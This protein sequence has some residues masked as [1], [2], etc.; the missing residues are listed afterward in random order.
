MMR[1][2]WLVQARDM[3]VA[4]IRYRCFHPAVALIGRGVKSAVFDSPI[5]LVKEIYKFDAVVIVKRLD[6]GAI[7]VAVAAREGGKAVLFDFCDDILSEAYRASMRE[8]NRAVFRAIAPLLDAVVTTGPAMTHRLRQYGY[9]LPRVFEIPDIAETQVELEAVAAFL[10]RTTTPEPAPKSEGAAEERGVVSTAEPMGPTMSKRAAALLD[11]PDALLRR[12]AQSIARSARRIALRGVSLVRHGPNWMGERATMVVRNPRWSVLRMAHRVGLPVSAGPPPVTSWVDG[13]GR[14]LVQYPLWSAMRAA[15]RLGLPVRPGPLPSN[16]IHADVTTDLA[17]RPVSTRLRLAIQNPGWTARRV[18]QRAG[19]PLEA[20]QLPQA[21]PSVPVVIAP[22]PRPPFHPTAPQAPPKRVVW[23]GNHGAPHSNFGVLSLIPAAPALRAVH[24]KTPI[25]LIVISNDRAK[26]EAAIARLGV[27]ARYVPWTPQAVLEEVT[28]AD[29]ALLTSG[30]DTFSEVKSS[31]RAL[32]AL[33]C[34]TP[35]VAARNPAMDVLSECVLMDD[36][37]LGLKSYFSDP[38]LVARHVETGRELIARRF[39]AKAIGGLWSKALHSAGAVNSARDAVP[40]AGAGRSR[41]LFLIDLV[42]DFDVLA[43]VIAHARASDLEPMVMVTEQA[44]RESSRLLRFLAT[45]ALTPT[46]ASAKALASGDARWLRGA[47]AV[48]LAAESSR[49]THKAAHALAQLA[50][51]CGVRAVSIQHGLESPGLTYRDPASPDVSFASDAI[52]TWV[53]AASLPAWVPDDV[54]ARCVRVGRPVASIQPPRTSDP[55]D[56]IGVFENLHWERFS[57]AYRAK[58]IEDLIEVALGQP[59]TEFLVRPHPAGRWLLK[60]LPMRLP[61]NVHVMN[62]DECADADVRDVLGRC[63]G[64]ITTPSTVALD[65]CECAVPVAVVQY[66][67]PD[68]SLYA[69]LP[70]IR[71]RPD[72]AAFAANATVDTCKDLR[73]AFISRFGPAPGAAGAILDL[74]LDGAR[75][76]A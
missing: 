11:D 19:L 42:Q 12:R 69:P 49:P 39:S 70:L 30:D 8:Q 67:Q 13:H 4:S 22:R 65:A 71:A 36:V 9:K 76:S 6:G 25:E 29:V 46:M 1:V 16:R 59:H 28:R 73:A 75:R 53:D 5:K 33:G 44:L 66:D 2:G 21:A 14:L 61:R 47:D 20:G 38:S 26:F 10:A 62:A 54:R 17:Q 64:A 45:H 68:L 41:V 37:E 57:E 52:L 72:W 31:N 50:R 58:F 63:R 56:R 34:G 7:D 15:Q 32:L 40:R 35:V 55:A 18:A 27:P 3:N 43:P 74:A 24:A 48:V 23:F 51:R 60:N